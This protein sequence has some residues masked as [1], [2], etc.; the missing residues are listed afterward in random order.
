[1]RIYG[2]RHWAEQSYKQLKDELGWANFQVRS[3]IAIRRHQVLVNCVFS[4]CWA[5]WFAGHP[6]RHGAA[7]Q[8][9]PGGGEQATRRRTPADAVLVRGAACRS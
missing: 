7:P 9:R 1:V 3:D 5:T 8:S 6:P 4:F 2:I